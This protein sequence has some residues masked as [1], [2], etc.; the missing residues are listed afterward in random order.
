MLPTYAL[1]FSILLD[2][3]GRNTRGSRGGETKLLLSSSSG[4]FKPNG[5]KY[6]FLHGR[7]VPA[8]WKVGCEIGQD[9]PEGLLHALLT[10]KAT[11]FPPPATWEGVD[12]FMRSSEIPITADEFT[13]LMHDFAEE[14]VES[15]QEIRAAYAL[16]D[17]YR[18]LKS[19]WT[20]PPRQSLSP[21][22]P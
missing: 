7:H 20:H 19:T 3:G 2:R 21:K 6:L 5:T 8:G 10:W 1:P 4:D 17:A 14:C 18:E 15:Q 13:I 11:G 22:R 16:A 12:Q 9:G